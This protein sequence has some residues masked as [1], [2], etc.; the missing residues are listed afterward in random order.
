MVPEGFDNFFVASATVAGALIGLLFVATAI[1]PEKV[2]HKK[3]PALAQQ[4]A[5]T[6]F[7]LLSNTLFISLAALIP[8]STVGTVLVIAPI[9]AAIGV[10]MYAIN[11][12]V[13]RDEGG[14]TY[15]WWVRRFIE[16]ALLAWQFAS[17]LSI[18]LNPNVALSSEFANVAVIVLAFFAI[19]VERAWALLGGQG[20]GIG[21]AV[22]MFRDKGDERK[23]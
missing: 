11:A 6:A 7:I 2:L 20:H 21:D 15:I 22:R 18:A 17:G 8:G 13:H 10:L 9:G 3:A 4:T 1:A 23:V 12:F 19:G 14:I 5:A 16:I